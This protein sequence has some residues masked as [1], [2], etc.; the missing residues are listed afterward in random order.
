MSPSQPRF[1]LRGTRDNTLGR[2]MGP[3]R[4]GTHT[5]VSLPTICWGGYE[6]MFVSVIRG[7][8]LQDHPLDT[9]QEDTLQAIEGMAPVTPAVLEKMAAPTRAVRMCRGPGSRRLRNNMTAV[10]VAT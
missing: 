10:Q 2:I 8:C 4:N 6:Q 5:L 7:V 9:R 1:H 3:L